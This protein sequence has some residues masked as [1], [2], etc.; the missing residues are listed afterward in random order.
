MLNHDV[1]SNAQPIYT[2]HKQQKPRI[3][4]AKNLDYW[5]PFYNQQE[6]RYRSTKQGIALIQ[7]TYNIGVIVVCFLLR[8]HYF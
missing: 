7:L 3:R 5:N 8:A 1:L 2:H 4:P 6:P